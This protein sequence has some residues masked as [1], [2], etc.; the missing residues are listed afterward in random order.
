MAGLFVGL[1]LHAACE[2]RGLLYLMSLYEKNEAPAG[3][4][5]WVWLQAA[6]L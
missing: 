4:Y 6:Q 1:L 5:R 2:D 3:K